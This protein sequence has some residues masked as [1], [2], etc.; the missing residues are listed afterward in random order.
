M[1]ATVTRFQS[2]IDHYTRSVAPLNEQYLS[3]DNAGGK[4]RGT[5][6]KLY[7]DIA[8]GIV[9][10]VDPTLV[11]K[12]NDYILIESRG[13]QYYKKV[14]VDLHLSLIHI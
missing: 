7:E 8:Q 3:E 6:G 5:V 13:G 9:Y 10:S 12:H 4:M 11:V 1:T 2:V 14:Q